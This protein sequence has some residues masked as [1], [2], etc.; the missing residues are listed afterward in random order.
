M[1]FLTNKFKNETYHLGPKEKTREAERT[2]GKSKSRVKK[3]LQRGIVHWQPPPKCG[4]NE[5]S[6][7]IHKSWLQKES[8]RPEKDRDAI[9]ERMELTYSFRRV[10]INEEKRPIKE[11]IREY[12]CLF[13]EQEVRRVI[14]LEFP[15]LQEQKQAY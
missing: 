9:K 14:I 11:I 1:N 15:L 7:K 12:P 5:Q 4:E 8:K 13:D 2:M 6:H 10:F 3:E